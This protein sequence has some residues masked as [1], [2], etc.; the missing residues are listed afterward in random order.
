[1]PSSDPH[2]DR[3]VALL[4]S[5][6][7]PDGDDQLADERAADWL[8]GWLGGRGGAPA[9]GPLAELRDLREGL[10]GLAA[11]NNGIAADAAALA[12]AAA[13]LRRSPVV[14]ELGDPDHAPGLVGATP[15]TDPARRA[16]ASAAAAYL[17]ARSGEGW[18]R[19]KACAAPD[20][21][22]AFVDTSR[23]R[24]RRWCDMADCGNRAKN[25]DWRERRRES[26]RAP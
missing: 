18:T 4:N 15:D 6:H 19:L 11:A 16:V 14:V 22:W 17:A 2:A 21:R 10:R 12:R 5:A 23:N 8:A 20:C 9:A 24:S 1:M 25:R 7:L 13:V 3:I 26:L